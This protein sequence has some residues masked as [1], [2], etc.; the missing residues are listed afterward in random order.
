L[1]YFVHYSADGELLETYPLPENCILGSPINNLIWA[2]DG[3]WLISHFGE[4]CRVSF[5]GRLLRS[6]KFEGSGLSNPWDAEFDEQ[7]NMWAISSSGDRKVYQVS[8]RQERVTPASSPTS[9]P[10]KGEKQALPRPDFK[11]GADPNKT[12]VNITNNLG[13]KLILEFDSRF[14]DSDVS[15][16]VEP[17][18]TWTMEV[19]ETGYRIFASANVPEPIAFSGNELL[20][21][22]YE[23][24]WVLTRPE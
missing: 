20:L 12:V 15:A 23:Y 6:G 5:D 22:G 24:T 9:T 19:A 7:G 14:G 16:I 17:G 2:T 8:T 13:G 11:R 4:W 18:Q 3:L 1:E 10:A 21:S